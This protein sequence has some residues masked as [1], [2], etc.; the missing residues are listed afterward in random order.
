[1]LALPFF[2]KILLALLWDF[3]D[4][5]VGRIPGFGTLWDVLGLL[6]A[7]LLWGAPGLIA[8]W[9]IFDVTDQGDAMVPTCTLIG[10]ITYGRK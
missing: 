6:V 4:F 8:A 9:E 2:I 7:L 5:I 1:M 10:L 3:L